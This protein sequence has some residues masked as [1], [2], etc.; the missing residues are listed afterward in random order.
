MVQFSS[1]GDRQYWLSPN[2]LEKLHATL[3]DSMICRVVGGFQRNKTRMFSREMSWGIKRK[4][5]KLEDYP[6]ESTYL[7]KGQYDDLVELLQNYTIY[8]LH[9]ILR[10]V[11]RDNDNK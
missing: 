6:L 3:Y 10:T 8:Y 7:H 5:K 2:W 9:I 4:F 1:I 11:V